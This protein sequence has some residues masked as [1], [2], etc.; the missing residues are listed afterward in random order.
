MAAHCQDKVLPKGATTRIISTVCSLGMLNPE[1]L[2]ETGLFSN[3]LACI[4][5]VRALVWAM[6]ATGDIRACQA[7]IDSIQSAR[8][9]MPC[10]I[11]HTSANQLTQVEG[12]CEN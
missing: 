10:G 5:R 2:K 9:R 3:A 6:G 4:A 11:P 1:I 7:G 8:L 12:Y